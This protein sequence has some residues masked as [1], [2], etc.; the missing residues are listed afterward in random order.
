MG[1]L[2]PYVFKILR[3]GCFYLTPYPETLTEI[4]HDN[5]VIKFLVNW[6]L[7]EEIHKY[8]NILKFLLKYK[9]WLGRKLTFIVVHGYVHVTGEKILTNAAAD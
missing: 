4:T 8:L 5:V 6:L 9:F 2:L 1:S 7:T 3:N